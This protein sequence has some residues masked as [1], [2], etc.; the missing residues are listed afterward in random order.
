[1]A[2]KL[3]QLALNSARHFEHS[4]I[5]ILMP[6]EAAASASDDNFMT[7]SREKLNDG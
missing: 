4:D 6:G 1:M 7:R 3:R 5:W 2:R